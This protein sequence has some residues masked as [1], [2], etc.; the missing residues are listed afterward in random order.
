MKL[1]TEK[2]VTFAAFLFV[3]SLLFIIFFIYPVVKTVSLSFH[4]W[5][6]FS[7]E[8]IYVGLQNYQEL[9]R[10]PRFLHS[11]ANNVRWLVFFVLFPPSLGLILGLLVD[12]KIRWGGVF[13]VVFFLPYTITPVAVAAIWRWLYG[14][15]TG[16]FNQLLMAVGL[17]QFIRPWLGEPHLAT[18]SIMLATL[19]WVVGF[20]FIVYF[21]GLRNIPTDLIEAARIDGASFW[22]MFRHITFPLLLPNTIVVVAMSGIEAMRIFDIIYAM[23]GGGPA[24]ATDVLATLMFDVSFNRLQMGVG[25]GVAVVLLVIS[26]AIILPYIIYSS[27]RLEGVQQ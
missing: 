19:W 20:S 8:S 27:R 9:F 13:K 15:Y 7:A 25:S 5:N 11:L 22:K 26:A 2:R 1:Q 12:Q 10:N 6:G 16:F 21:S 4:S 24:Y 14:L 18:Y 17:G 3:P 23:T